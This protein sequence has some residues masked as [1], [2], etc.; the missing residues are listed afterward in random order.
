[1]GEIR[2]LG[3]LLQ[4]AGFAM[5]VA[6]SLRLEVSYPDMLALMRDLR[7]MGETNVMHERLRRPMRREILARAGAVYAERFGLPD[8]RVRATFEVIFLTGWA[9]GPGQPKA[10]RP[11]SAV[12]RLAD[13]LGVPERGAGEKPG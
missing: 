13:A 1:M 5:P 10:L 12:A 2:A 8:G 7:A 11:G 6:D 4:R 3:G 9:P